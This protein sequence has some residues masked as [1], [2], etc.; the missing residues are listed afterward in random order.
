[1]SAPETGGKQ[2]SEEKKI[3]MD[4]KKQER[5]QEKIKKITDKKIL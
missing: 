5:R 4:K 2:E 1:M 3:Q